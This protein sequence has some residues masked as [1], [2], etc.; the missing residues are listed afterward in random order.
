MDY[1][2]KFLKPKVA[3]TYWIVLAILLIGWILSLLNFIAPSNACYEFALLMLGTSIFIQFLTF[4]IASFNI[5]NV[6][7]PIFYYGGYFFTL[8]G[9]VITHFSLMETATNICGMSNSYLSLSCKLGV[10]LFVNVLPLSA[11]VTI[12]AFV[13]WLYAYFA[14]ILLPIVVFRKINR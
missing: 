10:G 13:Y 6:L 3:R 7:I 5:P 1:V 11:S 8:I 12:G 2:N 9:Y 4:F 14:F